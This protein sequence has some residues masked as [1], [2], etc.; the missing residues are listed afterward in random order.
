MPTLVV[1]E[2]YLKAIAVADT[3]KELYRVIGSIGKV[4][5]EV[6]FD[7]PYVVTTLLVSVGFQAFLK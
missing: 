1:N 3:S 5:V 7:I 2:V 4:I 6:F